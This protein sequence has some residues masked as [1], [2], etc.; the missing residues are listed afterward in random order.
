MKVFIAGATG[1]LGRR[2]IVQLRERGHEVIGLAR[3]DANER[4]VRSLGG[5][6]RRGDLFDAASLARVAEG[7]EVV[8]HAA[9]AIPS[10][11]KITSDD[12]DINDRI[13]RDGTR[14]LAQC[15]GQIGARLYI[16][17]SIAWLARPPD[18]SFFDEQ[19]PSH[20]DRITQ[21][22][23]DGETIAT[24]AGA[25]A[26]FGVAVLRCGFFYAHD[27]SQIRML[28]EGLRH[29]KVPLVGSGDAILATLHADDAASAFVAAAEAGRSGLWHVIDDRPGTTREFLF[30]FAEKLG[31]PRPR[32]VAEW[33]AR[34]LAGRETVAFFTTSTRTSNARIKADLAWSPRY[35]TI[36]EGI[37]QIVT[38]WKEEDAS[39]QPSPR[40]S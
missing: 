18:E 8:I 16:Q 2:L 29:R 1:V 7:A 30:T 36:H 39:L 17:Q 38:A 14:A 33:V 6:S 22:A 4:V 5:E 25:A 12:W 9:T 11:M 3:S 21:S 15:A 20:P 27:S 34:L 23:L 26:G 10:K 24:E 31:A 32:H 40:N 28:G 19:S 35:P 37:D 13:R